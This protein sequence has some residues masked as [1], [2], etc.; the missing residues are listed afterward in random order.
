LKEQATKWE[1]DIAWLNADLTSKLSNSP[2]FILPDI[3]YL[4]YHHLFWHNN[5]ADIYSYFCYLPCFS[6]LFPASVE[7][8]E[9]DLQVDR[10]SRNVP[11]DSANWDMWEQLIALEAYKN[12]MMAYTDDLFLGA[13]E[14][15]QSL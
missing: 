15:Y 11:V 7:D 13:Q 6:S 1:V 14:A 12:A 9:K 5:H 8:V 10:L 2:T 3:S 4:T